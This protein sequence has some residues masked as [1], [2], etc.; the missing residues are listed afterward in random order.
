MTS[1]A[2]L[3]VLLAIHKKKLCISEEQYKYLFFSNPNPMWIYDLGTLNFLECNNAAV[4][5]Y[6]YSEEEFKKMT[7][8]VAF[9]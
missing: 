1:S 9:V 3:F 8:L 7:I 4:R 5:Q 2:L 6:G